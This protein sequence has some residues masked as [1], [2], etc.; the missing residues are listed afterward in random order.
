MKKE[1]M[2]Q[3]PSSEQP[4]FICWEKGASYLT[5]AQLLG[6]L[7]KSGSKELSVVQ[8]S[9]M[10]LN[11]KGGDLRS[12][13][14]LNRK[15][16]MQLPGIG[17]V[18]AM[19][20]ECMVELANRINALPVGKRECFCHPQDVFLRFHPRMR[21]LKKEHLYAIYLDGRNGFLKEEQLSVGTTN[22]SLISAKDIF[23]KALEYNAVY[24]ILIHNHP[25]GDPTPS[26][27]DI[28]VTE[29]VKLAGE[30]LE[31][32]LLDHIIVGD[33]TYTSMKECKLL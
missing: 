16:L 11:A 17:K 8:L 23:S 19:Q 29:M 28:A 15:E 6:V 21:F 33:N 32:Q 9:T 12:I 2:K 4:Y 31:I 27:A 25:S 3:L 26:E 7:L 30:L 1:N 10:L 13:A 14:K 22:A 18:K 5:D 20:M 24:L